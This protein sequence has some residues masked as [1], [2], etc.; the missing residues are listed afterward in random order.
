[1]PRM[2]DW[3]PRIVILLLFLATLALPLLLA[4]RPDAGPGD[5]DARRLVIV[6]P[7]NEQIRYEFAR[8]F[9][10]WHEQQFGQPVTI[11]WR[12]I[13][14]TAD[15]IRALKSNYRTKAK[16]GLEDEGI[17][18]DMMF[19]GGTYDFHYTLKPGIDAPVLDEQG[20]PVLDDQGQPRMRRV[21][22][23]QPV[24]RDEIGQ[25]LLD[26]AYPQP[27][28]AGEMLYDPD[29]HWWGVVLS[30]FGIV[31]NRDVLGYLDLPEP[32]T[33]SDLTDPRYDG[34]IALGDPSHSG[35]VKVTYNA[36]LQRYGFERGAATL[37]RCFA[38]AR[39]FT[40]SSSKIPLDVS[41]GEAA[42]GMCIDFYG[43]YQ[44]Q[45][46]GDGQR[47]GF[48]APAGVTLVSADPIAILRGAPHRE[49]AVRF[50]RFLLTEQGQALWDFRVG[51]PWGPEKFELRR[52]PIRPDIYRK[53]PDRLVDPVD[54]YEIARPVPV[55]ANDFYST[56]ALLLHAM[57]MDI[58][59]ELRAAWAA[60]NATRDPALRDRMIAEFDRMPAVDP[61]ALWADFNALDAKAQAYVRR[62]IP[63]SVDHLESIAT[64][65]GD[66][67][68]LPFEH[69]LLLSYR[70]RWS[71]APRT[72]LEDRLAWTAFF[73]RQYETVA[74]MAP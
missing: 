33:W 58:H 70:I 3:L 37:R 60:I 22:L 5:A 16:A 36:V 4:A 59:D 68:A 18:F 8:A 17:G 25:A 20:R 74:G 15:I 41:A 48:V 50:I 34:W 55:G 69:A 31:F 46:I 62:K 56:I 23:T 39:Y 26:A 54:P 52:A 28:I 2:R 13:G 73:R 38:N 12:T 57:A 51:D 10:R 24:A 71:N 43:R 44:S 47:V 32:T 1:M 49:T 19:G 72:E 64:Q 67:A 40:D 30:S 42:A 66:A 11:D 45:V 27:D 9:S 65:P 63:A 61:A 35:S 29:G 53:Y 14:G 7:H 6:T 21:P